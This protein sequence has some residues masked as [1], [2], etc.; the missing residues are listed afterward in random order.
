V[1]TLVFGTTLAVLVLLA[2]PAV[3]ADAARVQATVTVDAPMMSAAGQGGPVSAG[4]SA[5]AVAAPVS[6]P[7]AAGNVLQLA[8]FGSGAKAGGVGFEASTSAS[9]DGGTTGAPPAQRLVDAVVPAVEKAAPPTLATVGLLAV[10][11]AL[12]LGRFAAV[13][14]LGLYSRLTKSDLLDNEHRDRVYKLIQETPGLGV[15]EIGARSG[16]GWGTTVYHLDRLERAGFVASE[17][18]GLHKCYFP[19]GTLAREARKG[20][21][22]LKADTTRS[23]AEFLLVRPGATQ[24][25]LCG[26]L[27]LSASAASKQVSKL[28][29]AG[30]VRRERDWKTVHLHPT[31]ALPPLLNAP[32]APSP[33]PLAAPTLAA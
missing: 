8:S 26:A 25:E 1:R 19:V 2:A 15:S 31:D 29:E 5:P 33:A 32:A 7:P 6:T 10:L 18:G 17:R 22:A 23:I 13:G 21:G 20:L 12:G 24:S 27:G 9:D 11:Q 28:E 30:L 4:A 16:L 3:L 14:A